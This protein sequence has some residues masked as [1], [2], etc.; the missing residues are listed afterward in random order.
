MTDKEFAQ[1]VEPTLTK[2]MAGN[3]TAGKRASLDCQL[4]ISHKRTGISYGLRVGTS[5]GTPTFPVIGDSW[6][7]SGNNTVTTSNQRTVEVFL[8]LFGVP[9]ERFISSFF[10]PEVGKVKYVTLKQVLLKLGLKEKED[11]NEVCSEEN[12]SVL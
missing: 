11:K 2:F 9:W 7:V 4:I 10:A 1:L 5:R 12:F 6:R 3:P 8:L